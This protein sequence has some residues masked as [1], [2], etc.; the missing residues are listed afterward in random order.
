[1]GN[2]KINA[3]ELFAMIVL[4]ELGSAL[5]VGLGMDAKNDA[6]LSIL[7]GW[8]GG[9][10]L[11][12]VYA[13]LFRYYPHLPLT[14]YLR[15]IMGSYAGWL[16][17]L[18]YVLY[19]IYIAARVLRDFGE[20][21]TIS[22]YDQT[23]LFVINALM[24]LTIS[25]VI[26]KGIEVFAR[27]GEMLFGLLIVVGVLGNIAIFVSG[28][29][30]FDQLAPLLKEGWKPVFKTAFPLTFTFPFGEMITFTMILPFVN[31]PRL[32]V[33]F[34]YA[35]MTISALILSW[36]SV[37][38]ISILGVDIASRSTFPLLAMIG[39]VNIAE[40]LQRLD[41][42]AILTL[43]IG[44]FFKIAVFFITAVQGAADL[45]KVK[46]PSNLVVPIG[47]IILFTSIQIASGLTE[48]LE[49][50]L[51]VVPLYVHLPLQAGIPVLLLAV[52]WLKNR[53]R[54]ADST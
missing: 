21:L 53:K 36:T 49:E 51:K 37:V 6:W 38:N 14:G 46:D 40:F 30:H 1:M 42:L 16:I 27:T 26:Y 41:V 15:V 19:F 7:I 13:Q 23:P 47:I 17:G 28:L 18:I 2:A 10:A 8:A 12:F 43:I 29:I 52:T 3:G 32:G 20:L 48:H 25:Y 45:F 9:M 22:T 31:N 33:K 54:R 5:L 4:F 44:G 50:G 35:G 39:K 34:S 11:F 24:I